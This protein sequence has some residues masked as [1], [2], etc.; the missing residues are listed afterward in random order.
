MMGWCKDCDKLVNI[1]P[2][3]RELYGGTPRYQP[4]PHEKPDGGGL[5]P[6]RKI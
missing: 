3:K 2:L 1:R 6:G 4:L 5:C